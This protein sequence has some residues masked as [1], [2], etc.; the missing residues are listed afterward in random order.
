MHDRPVA[1]VLRAELR[2][3]EHRRGD[4]VV[5]DVVLRAEQAVGAR[6]CK[7]DGIAKLTGSESYGADAIP[8]D[9]LRLRVIRSPYHRARFHIGNLKKFL[10]QNPG[11]DRV[12]TAAD[13]PSNGFGIYPGIKDQPVLADGEA[14]FRGEAVAAVIGTCEAVE[15]LDPGRFPVSWKELPPVMGLD[16]AMAPRAHPVQTGKPDNLLLDGGVRKGDPASAWTA[17]AAIAAGTFETSF[18]EHAYIEPEAGWA[19]RIGNRVE[20]QVTTQTPYMDRDEVA[21]VMKLRPEQVRLVRTGWV[22]VL[23]ASSTSRCS[24]SSRSVRG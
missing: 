6:A 5:G 3:I 23:A 15:A 2:R 12:L 4:L 19:M 11:I 20:I 18:V 10:K 22:G 9:A 7:V 21:L 1:A 16:A 13:V 14:R 17:C 24:R 8:T